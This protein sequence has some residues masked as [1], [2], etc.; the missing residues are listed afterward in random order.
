MQ[1]NLLHNLKIN[2]AKLIVL[3][4]LTSMIK[5]CLAK[6]EYFNMKGIAFPTVGCGKLRYSADDVAKCFLEAAKETKLQVSICQ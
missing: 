1:S 2:Y 5:K 6:A 3:Q 4:L